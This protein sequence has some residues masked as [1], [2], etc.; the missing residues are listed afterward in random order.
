METYE[1]SARKNV[2]KPNKLLPVFEIKIAKH[3]LT[4]ELSFLAA[5]TY[6]IFSHSRM[7]INDARSYYIRAL[8]A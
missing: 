2:P 8:V 4:V 6:P 1:K 5:L 3:I 7:N